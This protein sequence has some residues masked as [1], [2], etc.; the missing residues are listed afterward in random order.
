MYILFYRGR[1][2]ISLCTCYR[3]KQRRGRD[4]QVLHIRKGKDKHRVTKEKNPLTF[5][6]DVTS[7]F[8]TFSWFRQVIH[9]ILVS[10]SQPQMDSFA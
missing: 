3:R 6:S 9:F 1:L 8:L 7:S 4:E 5:Y 2:E 10:H